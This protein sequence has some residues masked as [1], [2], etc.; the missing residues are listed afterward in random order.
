MNA[1]FIVW[2]ISVP[3]SSIS[4]SVVSYGS[5]GITSPH[6]AS[7]SDFRVGDLFCGAGGLS[8]GL[9]ESGM[10][11]VVGVDNS[12]AAVATAQTNFEHDVHLVD[13][14]DAEA[15][16]EL[17]RP[18]RLRA[19]AGGSPCQDFSSCGQRQEGERADLTHALI[20]IGIGLGCEYIVTEN[21]ALAL[22]SR[23]Y[24]A[25]MTRLRSEGYG[26]SAH[27][28]DAS[29]YAVP[30]ARKRAILCAKLG[31]PDN[32]MPRPQVLSDRPM[33]VRDYLGGEIGVDHY[34]RH[35]RSYHRRAVFSIDE[36]SPTVRGCNRPVP[37]GH[38]PHPGDTADIR[39]VR[40]LTTAERARLQTFP[41]TYKWVGTKT[42]VEQMIGNAVPC[43]L[44]KVIGQAILNDAMQSTG[45]RGV[46]HAA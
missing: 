20:R 34:Y 25:A 39:T 31:A 26:V 13:L 17:L 32:W 30:Q 7:T 4:T 33:T 44:A 15:A 36:P 5:T 6:A 41:P 2:S 16:I 46:L 42:E 1:E 8:V 38:K 43:A 21:V 19:V 29:L 11:V 45:V 12:S 35:P 18:Y 10:D 28:L 14:S 3:L 27:V 40:P 37:R 9:Q 24:Q 23:V 22:S